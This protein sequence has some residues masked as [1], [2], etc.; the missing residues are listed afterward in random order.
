MASARTRPAP[1]SGDVQVKSAAS[2]AMQRSS[3]VFVVA[4]LVA[5]VLAGCGS[6]NSSSSQSSSS[7]SGAGSSAPSTPAANSP[8]AEQQSAAAGDIPDNQ[9]YLRFRD[10]A[11]GYSFL[12]PE[13][14]T[15]KGGGNDITF[16]NKSNNISVRIA[17]GPSPT[18]S[19]LAAG[20]QRLKH[21][22]PSL[23]FSPP[24]TV[25]L[26]SG[27]AVKSTYT[28]KSK[29]NSVT[30]KTLPLVVDRY[31][32]AHAGKLATVDL[33]RAKGVDTADAYRMIINSF[34][35]Q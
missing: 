3:C 27:T 19:S 18:T 30:G 25:R 16:S 34:R 29:P 17:P 11:A 1:L 8:V 5:A 14:W 6:S 4:V 21:S 22:D 32:L 13:G 9:V 20:L 10:A 7:A 2:G 24:T 33:S 28:T 35:W 15:R 31:Q 23:T 26:K 12:Y